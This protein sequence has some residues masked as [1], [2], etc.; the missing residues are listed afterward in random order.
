MTEDKKKRIIILGGGFGGIYTAM[1]LEKLLGKIPNWEILLIN[2]EN[3]FVYQP[4]LAEVVGGSVGILDTVSPISRLLPRC[5]LVMREIEEIDL[6]KKQVVVSPKF[7]H[8]SRAFSYDHLVLGLGNVTDFRGATG[9]HEHALPF[10]NLADSLRIRNHFIDVMETAPIVK[11]PD[12]RKRLLTFV[13]GGGGFSGTEVVAEDNDLVRKMVKKS[14][15]IDPKEVRVILVHSKDRLMERELPESLSRYAEKILKK[16][17]VEIRF[18]QRLKV[19]TPQD[20]VLDTGEKIGSKTIIS[21]VPSSPNPI[22]EAVKLPQERGK[23]KADAT[24]LVEGSDHIWAIG[25]CAKITLE[26]GT[27]CP[28]TAQFA[29]REA[30]VL[31]RNIVAKINGKQT[32]P[33]FFKSIG[34]L[35]ALGHHSAVA[36][37]FGKI[38][39]SG[40]LA[41]IMWRG[42]YW[43]KLPGLDRKIKVA[44]SWMLDMIFPIE[45]VQLQTAPSQGIAKLHFESGE[46]IFH[47]GDVGDYLYIITE[48]SVDIVREMEGK[49]QI[50]A[51]LG[52]GE[53]FGEVALLNQR[54][55]TATVRCSEPTD[56]LALRKSDFGVLIANFRDL[57]DTFEKTEK[58]RRFP[59]DKG[60]NKAS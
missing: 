27:I 19:A 44:F 14:K 58:E 6:E 8:K 11:D 1:H 30:K 42:I 53:F 52:K 50:I 47:E 26:D 55:R 56:V 12:L 3:Y 16:R 28:P 46:V 29:I 5:R 34:M 9:L 10:K 17:G 49:E 60:F 2:R 20:A 24:M 48:G 59:E 7:T 40:L 32:K 13:I 4:M 38:R 21:T 35:G 45:E 18:G 25:D 15:D 51:H 57:R 41:W 37:L 39:L 33:F 23:I 54:T 22:I 36:E 43:V 31:A